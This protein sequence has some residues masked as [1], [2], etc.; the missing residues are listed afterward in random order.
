MS[1]TSLQKR[2]SYLPISAGSPLRSAVEYGQLTSSSIVTRPSSRYE[3]VVAAAGVLLVDAAD[4]VMAAD[5]VVSS[6]VTSAE[7]SSV[8]DGRQI[9]VT[10]QEQPG[11]G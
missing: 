9:V 3:N 7:S 8:S 11:I 2:A 1:R 4:D 10:S 6:A 5:G